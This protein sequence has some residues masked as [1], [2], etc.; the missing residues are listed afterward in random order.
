[1][2]NK[3]LSNEQVLQYKNQD[4]FFIDY[5]KYRNLCVEAKTLILKDE[6]EPILIALSKFLD[7]TCDYVN[8]YDDKSNDLNKLMKEH[9]DM[10]LDEFKE[11]VNKLWKDIS[12][13]H[14]IYEIL[15]KPK[16]NTAEE[17]IEAFW[18]K[19]ENKGIKQIKKVMIDIYKTN[20]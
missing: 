18:R 11:K 20:M 14:V 16:V 15:P 6:R 4:P 9:I 5:Y 13:D 12:S 3:K 19:E 8:N 7:Y 10:E 1:M 2:E 17:E